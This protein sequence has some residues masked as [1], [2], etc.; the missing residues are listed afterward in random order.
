[1]T[2]GKQQAENLGR[3]KLKRRRKSTWLDNWTAVHKAHE[4]STSNN[5][6]VQRTPRASRIS[7]QPRN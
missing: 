2:Q 4:V 3:L 7:S 6:Q 5:E 1:M